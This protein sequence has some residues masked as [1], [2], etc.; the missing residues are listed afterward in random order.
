MALPPMVFMPPVAVLICPKPL[1]QNNPSPPLPKMVAK[2]KRSFGGNDL[3]KPSAMIP[4]FNCQPQEG[5]NSNQ[6]LQWPP[7]S[8]TEGYPSDQQPN[9]KTNFQISNLSP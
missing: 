3:N 2:S 5:D 7:R 9:L 6:Q 1:E 8:S 4:G